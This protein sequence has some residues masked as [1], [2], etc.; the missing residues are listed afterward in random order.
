MRYSEDIPDH[1][2]GPIV[3]PEPPASMRGSMRS[4]TIPRP[5][6][7]ARRLLILTAWALGLTSPGAA[8]AHFLWLVSD[9]QGKS[10]EVRAFLSETPIPEGPEFLK[11]IAGAKITAGGRALSWTKGE[12]TY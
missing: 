10:P 9:L 12:D 5:F 6:R 8:R 2:H 1:V 11:H 3:V 4:S 7:P